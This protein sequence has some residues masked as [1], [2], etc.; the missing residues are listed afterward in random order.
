MSVIQTKTVE[1]SKGKRFTAN[2]EL[3]DS[4]MEV[5]EKCKDRKITDSRFNNMRI[6]ACRKDWHGVGSYDEA[7]SLMYDGWNEKVVGLQKLLN[8]NKVTQN[9]KRITFQNDVH[10]FA[11]IVP[12]AIL[13]VPT[14]MINS[15]YRPIKS[16]IISIYYDMTISSYNTAEQIMNNGRKVVEAIIKLENSGYRVN[17]HTFQTYT[18]D[19]KGDVL[20][21]KV[22]SANQPLD[23]KRLCFP[24]MHSAMFR[25]IGFD[26]YSKF[27]KGVY[28][29]AY[30]SALGYNY[31]YEEASKIVKGMFGDDAV[32]LLATTVQKNGVDYIVDQ[33]KGGKYEI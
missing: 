32:Y 18:S 15:T 17:L 19:G 21:I 16:K 14:S 4:S 12:L 24:I 27:P 23:L 29:S 6:K 33:L 9:C 5:V 28:R 30:G 8:A 3:F 13:G 7:L 26:W 31:N 20:A 2:I 1:Y 25:V 22:K 11:P 10:G